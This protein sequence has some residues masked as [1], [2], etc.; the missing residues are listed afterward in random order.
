MA[1]RDGGVELYRA[2]LMFGICLLHSATMCGHPNVWMQGLLSPCVNG[3]VFISGYYGIKFRPSKVFRLYGVGLF[4][5]WAAVTLTRWHFGAECAGTGRYWFDVYRLFKQSFWFLHAYVVLMLLAPLVDGAMATFRENGD[6]QRLVWALLPP[7]MLVFVW[8]AWTST[9]KLQLL[10]PRSSG[11]EAYSGLTLLGTYIVARCFRIFDI[12]PRIGT[13]WLIPAV[14]VLAVLSGPAGLY[15]YSTPVALALAAAYF[16]FFAKFK[17]GGHLCKLSALSPSL[18]SVYLLH[19]QGFGFIWMKRCEQWLLAQ[20]VPLF[21]A[22]F[23]TALAI[24]FACLLIDFPRRAVCRFMARFIDWV[25]GK[26][27]D[28]YESLLEW[29]ASRMRGICHE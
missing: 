15:D 16:I 26:L 3:F 13:R 6:C 1:K 20:G 9:P 18:F 8:A 14:I 7:L 19:S 2:F 29:I 23:A 12:V 17:G 4:C 25:C 28:A 5:A 24:F 11:V 10:A 21:A 22:Y 27:D